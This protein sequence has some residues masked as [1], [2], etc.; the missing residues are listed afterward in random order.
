MERGFR[1]VLCDGNYLQPWL[2]LSCYT[3]MH[4]TVIIISK[5]LRN[6]YSSSPC[7]SG[8]RMAAANVG[9]DVEEVART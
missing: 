7:S 4:G 3:F 2:I 1:S 5:M 9:H 8:G 6:I